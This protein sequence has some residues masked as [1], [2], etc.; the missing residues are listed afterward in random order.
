MLQYVEILYSMPN[1]LQYTWVDS[2]EDAGNVKNQKLNLHVSLYRE[3]QQSNH[4]PVHFEGCVL[5]HT[6]RAQDMLGGPWRHN[7]QALN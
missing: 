1:R 6:D 4:L 2:K 3:T 5:S 7:N